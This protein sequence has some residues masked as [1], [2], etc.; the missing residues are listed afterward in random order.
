MGVKHSIE[1]VLK[2]LEHEFKTMKELFE[3]D[4]W[5]FFKFGQGGPYKRTLTLMQ[6]KAKEYDPVLID[7]F[8]LHKETASFNKLI[9]L[10]ISASKNPKDRH[11][12]IDRFQRQINR[13]RKII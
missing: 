13:M 1:N 8:G 9:V 3:K 12:D 5:K 4:D 10:C 11:K 6:K 7:H 2:I